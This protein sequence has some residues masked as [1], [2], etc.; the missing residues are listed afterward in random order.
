MDTEKFNTI[1]MNGNAILNNN[2]TNWNEVYFSNE[3]TTKIYQTD[4]VSFAPTSTLPTYYITCKSKISKDEMLSYL[5]NGDFE[6]VVKL[7]PEIISFTSDYVEHEGTVYRKCYQN[8]HMSYPLAS[9]VI[10]L[11]Q[12]RFDIDIDNSTYIVAYS[13]NEDVELTD[14]SVRAKLNGS[15]CKITPISDGV[16]VE[17]VVN[18]EPG[19]WVPNWL[20]KTQIAKTAEMYIRMEKL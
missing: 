17:R 18:A 15:V 5:W 14:G 9:R 11:V 12:R 4:D 8:T 6:K 7:D 16:L 19:G 13:V 2:K 1:F 20:V 3:N 10:E